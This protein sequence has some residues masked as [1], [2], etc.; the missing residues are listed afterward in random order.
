MSMYPLISIII[1]VYNKDKCIFRTLESV[2][3]QKYSD[4]E[5]IIV[6]DGSTDNSAEII[7]DFKNK[8]VRYFYKNN[9]GPSAARNFGVEHAN[10]EW[11]LFLDADDMLCPNALGHFHN[12][13]C[14]YNGIKCF[15]ANH[16]IYNNGTLRLYSHIYKSGIVNNPFKAWMYR[17][18]MPRAGAALFHK[19]IL[20]KYKHKK[21]LRRYED[22]EF[23]F[24]VMRNE[25]FVSSKTPVMIYNCE[26]LS[27]S[28]ARKDI[29]E[30]FLAYL[31]VN[32]KPHWERVVL[33]DLYMQCKKL[34][35]QEASSLY[36]ESDFYKQDIM[37]DYLLCKKRTEKM[38]KFDRILNFLHLNIVI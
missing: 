6:D 32:D 21:N 3:N 24:N 14:R 35:P 27:A 11:I 13:I 4:Y 10:A 2:S 37:N 20:K 28:K 1:P 26:S 5:I 18:F 16:Y 9:E 25:Q 33:L 15:C 22:A 38:R 31:S 36:K 17:C 34:Y 30:D 8:A 23:L 29:R 7:H 19:E 12:L